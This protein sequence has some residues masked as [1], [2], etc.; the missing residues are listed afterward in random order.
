MSKQKFVTLET[1]GLCE[2]IAELLI[3]SYQE[4]C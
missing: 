1:M 4:K 3:A 2:L